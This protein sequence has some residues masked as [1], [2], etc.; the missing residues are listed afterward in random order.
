M[1]EIPSEADMAGWARAGIRLVVPGDLEWPGQLDVLGD[2]RPWALWVRG[3][4]D[5][6]YACLRSVAMV[7]TRAASAYGSYVAKEMAVGLAEHGWTLVS[8]GAYG[9]DGSVHRGALAG[10]GSTIAVLA[11]GVDQEYPGGH[12]E[13]F[14][15]MRES[16]AVVSEAPPGRAPTRPAFLIRNRSSPRLAVARSSWRPRSAAVP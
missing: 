8:G 14:R 6:R 2:S 3:N 13:L 9:I 10:E 16:G 12:H 1:G 7:G 4:A 15:A 5:L 11:C